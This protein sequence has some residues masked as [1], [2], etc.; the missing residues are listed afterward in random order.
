MLRARSVR[1]PNGCLEWTGPVKKRGHGVLG[2]AGDMTDSVHRLS[3][4]LL[5]GPIP[6]G[7]CVLHHC[8]NPPCW[9][10]D[11]LFL[12]TRRT[13]NED[14]DIK[15]RFSHRLTED[16]VRQIRT[17]LTGQRGERVA[18]A[19]EFGVTKSTIT[20]VAQRRT[21]RLVV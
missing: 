14:R 19:R 3:Y 7:L 21:W 5:K 16:E 20:A 11:H 9:E 8:D 15:G 6:P 1:T 2:R 17:R 4:E 18:L 10:P 13:N 12:G